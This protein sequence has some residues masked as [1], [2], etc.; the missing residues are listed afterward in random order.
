[1][2]CLSVLGDVA[3]FGAAGLMGAMWLWE[4]R[5]SRLREE[6]LSDA[7]HRVMRDEERLGKLIEV[8]EHNTAALTRFTETQHSVHQALTDLREEIRNGRKT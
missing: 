6:Q 4:R 2:L 7:H 1:M 3:S 8:V 5:N